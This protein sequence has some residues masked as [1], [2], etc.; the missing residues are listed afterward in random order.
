LCNCASA[1]RAVT[2]SRCTTVEG[3]PTQSQARAGETPL[4]G[5][6]LRLVAVSPPPG[7]RA[8][9]VTVVGPSM[10]RTLGAGVTCESR[11]P[12][13]HP[14]D[15]VS[16]DA[17]AHDL[18]LRLVDAGLRAEDIHV[19]YLAVHRW[20][21]LD[22]AVAAVA[23]ALRAGRIASAYRVVLQPYTCVVLLKGGA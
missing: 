12:P 17:F 8:F 3:A 5:M 2:P 7:E 22:G 20:S 18:G 9:D 6:T 1:P 23:D 19:D 13:D 14:C 11:P 21:D 10:R 16:P 15:A 4:H